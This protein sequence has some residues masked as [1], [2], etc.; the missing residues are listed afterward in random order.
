MREKVVALDDE[1]LILAS[2]EHLFED[3]YEVFAVS[4]AQEALRLASENNIAVILCD[5]RMPGVSGHEFLG[6]VRDFSKATRVMMSG[7][8]DMSALAEAVNSGQIFGYIAKPW[9][10]LKLKVQMSAAVAHFNLVQQ[11][12]RERVLLA[13]LMDNIPD[14]IYFKDCQSCFTRV[15][16]AHARALGAKDSAECVGKSDADYFDPECALRWSFEEADIVSSGRPQVERIEQLIF[17]RGGPRWMST[18]KVPMFERTGVVSGIA[19]ISRDITALKNSE[20]QLRE[21]SEH[22]RMILETANDAFI[23]MDADGVLTA[24]NPRAELTFGWTAAEVLGRRWSDI[25]IAPAYREP[26]AQGAEHFLAAVQA[27]APGNGPIELVAVGRDGHEF[28]V[29]ATVW[30]VRSAGA[31]SFNAFLRDISER[32]RAE[33]ARNRKAALIRLLQSVTVAANSSSTIEHTARTCLNQIC[34][35]TGWPIGHAYLW[36]NNSDEP[37]AAEIWRVDGESRRACASGLPGRILASGKPEWIVDLADAGQS[38]LRSGFGFP[39]LVG[40]RT[41]ALLEFYSRES[42]PRDEEFLSIMEHIGSELA[43]VIKRQHAEEDLQRAKTAAE[44]ANRAKSEFLTTMSHEIRTP[45]NAILGMADLLLEGSLSE[46]QRDYV[47]I[48]QRAGATLLELINGILDLAKVESGRFDLESVPFNLRE[49]VQKIIEMMTARATAS[50]LQLTCKILPDVPGQLIGDPK[51]L[52]QVLTNLIG[53]ALKFTE[54]GSVSLRVEREPGGAAGWLRFHVADTGIGIAAENM[55]L[56]FGR[57]TQADSSITRKFGGT[58]LGLAISKGL[59]EL[60]GGQM[61]CS[62]EVAKGS[63]FLFT[64][65]F[66]M[67]AESESP[68]TGEA[69][70][71]T[72]APATPPAPAPAHRILVV[73]DSKDNIVLM[74]AYLKHSGFDLS[75]AENGKS[76]IEKAI[77]CKPHVVL[78]DVQMPV[79]DGLE[80]TRAIRQL[81]S[82]TNAPPM[83]I[84]ALTAHA[85]LGEAEKSMQAGCTE[86]LTKPIKKATLLEA[87]ARYIAP[88]QPVE[89]A[90]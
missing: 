27:S 35:H 71:I 36:T 56:I 88:A 90:Q 22:N 77:A 61:S 39:V 32:R 65:P 19:G 43:Q 28:P 25:A 42:A 2:L 41:L 13:A 7:Y 74:K 33:E 48:F 34:E 62:S 63:T 4:D 40:D 86:H 69:A 84:L 66:G 1:D 72:P 46:E 24:W 5:E 49:L 78:M 60:M 9:E 11:V 70:A 73:E 8:A 52:R 17:P 21:Q 38:G 10:P 18:T 30:P 54:R 47:R 50:G 87:I 59:V 31:L 51:R 14:S 67:S 29:E 23:G 44:S 55:E 85:A 76:A 37:V 12:D 82:E 16:R 83:P 80:A 64:V 20:E 79:M 3:D 26:H 45:M 75:F 68:Q 53:N 57:F 15:N 6:R 89:V 58:G 81:E